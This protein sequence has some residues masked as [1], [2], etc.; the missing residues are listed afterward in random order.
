MDNKIPLPRQDYK[1]LCRCSTFN[2]SKYI[3]DTMRGF[4]MQETTFPYLCAIQDDCSTDGGQD[5]ICAFL[6]KEF[7]MSNS[8]SYDTDYAKI[9]IANHKIN[10]NC[11]FI[12]YLLSFN[13]YTAKIKKGKYL[14]PLRDICLY[15]A[16]C[17]GDDCWIHPHKLQMQADFLDSHPKCG[18][19]HTDFNLTDGNKKHDKT[20]VE[21][22]PSNIGDIL[23]ANGLNISTLTVLYRISVLRKLPKLYKG[24]GWPMGDKPLW[25]EFAHETDVCYIDEVTA[26][27]R[28]LETSASHHKD[29]KKMIAFKNAGIEITKYYASVFKCSIENDLYNNDYYEYIIRV[30]CRLGEKAIAEDY[31]KK[32]IAKN[33]LSR[34][35]KLF[36]YCSKCSILKTLVNS[37]IKI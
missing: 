10:S 8:L 15:E 6:D 37:Y 17:E 18:L 30:A 23:R 36:Y 35:A 5:V 27:Y 21:S 29:I 14:A 25:Y 4:V 26:N 16:P 28:I 12:V 33:K 20:N 1:V 22:T 19:V 2:H 11:T 3:E 24:K 9:I 7:D 13:H 31:Y 32:A 34:K